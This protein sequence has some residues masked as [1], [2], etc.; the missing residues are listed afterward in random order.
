[1]EMG[2]LVA[3]TDFIRRH[4]RM[5][6]PVGLSILL[7]VTLVCSAGSRFLAAGWVFLFGGGIFLAIGLLALHFIAH[8]I[9]LLRSWNAT[10]LL[11]TLLLVSHALLFLSLSTQWDAFDGP[12]HN[13]LSVLFSIINIELSRETIN[14]LGDISHLFVY[15]L[16]VSWI[17]INLPW[18]YAKSQK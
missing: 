7:I 17:V 9:V 4:K 14:K 16:C 18:F 13:G 1:M 11:I 15:A 5:L 2:M 12:A 8:L 10:P 6:V 3:S